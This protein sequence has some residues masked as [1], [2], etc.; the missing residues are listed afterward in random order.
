MIDDM[1]ALK[2]A[3]EQMDAEDPDEAQAAKDRTAQALSDAKLSFSKIAELIEQRRLL[4]RPRIV[5]GI[6]RMDQP[7]MLGDA[8]F[9]DTGSA[10]RR[11]GQS[12]RQI[13]EALE[14]STRPTPASDPRYEEPAPASEPLPQ[15]TGPPVYDMTDAPTYDMPGDPVEP[16]E[17]LWIRALL[18]VGSIFLFPFRHPIRLL[19]IA[20][21]AYLLSYFLSF[22]SPNGAA[23]IRQTAD[24]AVLSVSSFVDEQISRRSK[25][26]AAAPAPPGPKPSPTTPPSPSLTSVTPS[27]TPAPAPA[28]APPAISP[29]PSANTSAPPAS[30]R[31]AA[32]SAA[33][34]WTV[35]AS[36]PASPPRRE[37]KI[38]P[39]SRPP[40]NCDR[41]PSSRS[42]A[43]FEGNRS[44]ALDDIIPDRMRRRSRA[45]G[46]CVAGI[47]GCYWGGINY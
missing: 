43:P 32:P 7:G 2:Q 14:F 12:F 16:R 6:K 30:S 41:Y 44:S 18:R 37:A 33:P 1:A 46:P 28:L 5:S 20:L 21:V 15:M 3:M 29:A 36:P 23:A 47:G 17:S 34:L 25:D 24:R 38:A 39:P 19:A 40:V 10:L 42:C 27:A 11:E 9:R 35:P 26:T 13:A 45:G 22:V 4:L 31:P 8:A